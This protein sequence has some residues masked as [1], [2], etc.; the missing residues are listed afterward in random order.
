VLANPADEVSL[1][2]VLNTPP[3]GIG[4]GSIAV[5]LETAVQA[6]KPMWAILPD[7]KSNPDVSHA[8]SER[9]EQF[10][11]MIERYRA[12]L[13]ERLLSELFAGLLDEIAYRAEIERV[14]KN[15]GD[16]EARWAAVEELVNSIALYESRS[17]AP[18]LL[19]F[20]EETV[21]SG[22]EDNKNDDKE[23]QGHAVTL[24]T[25]HSAKGLEF[26][27]VYLVGMEEGLLPHQRSVA[28]GGRNI[29]EERRLGYV[30]VTRAQ[31][32][33]T[34]TMSKTRMKWGKPRPS[35][36]SRFVMEMRGETERARRIAEQAKQLFSQ[37]EPNPKALAKKT[38]RK[39]TSRRPLAR[40]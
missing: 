32:Y 8:V 10:C 31:E 38:R 7:A 21:L 20:L 9:I 6:G 23:R 3:R 18:S 29:D 5:L 2:R 25:L 11:Q 27:H 24:M 39:K 36:V 13:T 37:P 12:K 22:R 35:L 1:L 16:V 40:G 33:L 19:G 34:V 14:Q 30:G 17:E 26:P 28:D 15:P 4:T